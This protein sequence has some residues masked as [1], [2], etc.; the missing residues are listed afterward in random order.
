[1]SQLQEGVIV[2]TSKWS[3][4]RKD[5]F[6]LALSMYTGEPCRICGQLMQY[7]D[8]S[9]TVWAGYSEGDRARIA[10][11]HCWDRQV[12]QEEWAHQ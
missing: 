2:M 10:H 3:L 8:L 9:D 1:M 11:G 7:G 12:P 5:A 6:R 4:F